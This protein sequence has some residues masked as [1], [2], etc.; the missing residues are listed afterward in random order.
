MKATYILNK[1][2]GYINEDNYIIKDNVFGVFDGATSLDKYKDRSG[3]TGGFLASRIAKQTFS[4][5]KK[6]LKEIAVDAN[7]SIKNEM[8]LRG[9]DINKKINLWSTSVAAVKINKKDFEWVQIGD[10]LILVIYNDNSFKLLVNNYDHDKKILL[11][12]KKLADKKANN[13]RAIINNNIIKLRKTMNIKYGIM[14]GENCMNR[15]LNKGRKKLTGVKHIII[16]TDGLFI[17]KKDPKKK[18]DFKT[19]VKLFLEG[20]LGK[21]KN[22]VREIE[23]KDPNCWIYPRYK[24]HDDMAAIAISF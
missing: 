11:I 6:S 10:S 1:G 13:I 4:K 21:I 3:K 19:F 18:D 15:F 8:I 17:P 14:N 5:H 12:W 9:I 16:F 22:Y 7:L 20:G 2:S 24:Q 23:K